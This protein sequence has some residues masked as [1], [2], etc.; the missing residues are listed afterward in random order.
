MMAQKTEDYAT[1]C[2]TLALLTSE[3]SKNPS[4]LQEYKTYVAAARAIRARLKDANACEAAFFAR[5]EQANPLTTTPSVSEGRFDHEPPDR[6]GREREY[7]APADR[8]R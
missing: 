5:A 3:A 8:G 7:H 4:N 2:R 1:T 6:L